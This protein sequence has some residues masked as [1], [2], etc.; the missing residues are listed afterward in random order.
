MSN[1]FG[2]QGESSISESGLRVE[3]RPLMR[4]VYLWMATGLLLTA[5]V[6]VGVASTPTLRQFVSNPAVLFGAIIAELALVIGLSWG[7]RRLSPGAAIAMFFVYAAINGLT[8]SL[9][10]SIYTKGTISAAFFTTAGLFGAMTVVGF[11]TKLDLSQYR[12]YF[13]MGLIGLVIA[14]VVNM[15]IGSGP[16]DLLI[17]IVGVVLFTALTAYD[18]QKIKRMAADPTIEADGSLAMKLSIMGALTLYLDFINLFLFLL[19]LFGG[20]RRS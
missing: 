1:F 19:R 7:L 20:G 6:S 2:S 13:I 17:S 15:F 5:A 10:F 12:S 8:L 11:T 3:I 9:I 16:L 4:Q 18:T 14:M